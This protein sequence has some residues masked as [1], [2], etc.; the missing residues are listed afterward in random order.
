MTIFTEKEILG[1]DLNEILSLTSDD[2]CISLFS[3][4]FFK[5]APT[6]KPRFEVNDY[7]KLPT[8]KFNTKK[9]VWT[10]IGIYLVNLHLIRPRFAEIFGYINKPF[11]GKVLGF[12]EGKLSD[13]LYND[14]ISTDDMA[15][16]Y[17][18]LQW[19]GGHDRFSL[20]TPS[21]T[22]AL[23][24]PAPGLM[25][26]KRELFKKYEKELDPSN[27]NNAL[28]AA[29]I[30][31]ELIE[32]AENYLKTCEGYENFSSKS[33]VN[34]G[35][36]YK[37]MN[38]MKG[39]LLN[40]YT[41]QYQVNESEYNTGIKKGEYVSMSDSAVLGAH[42]RAVNTA[43]GGYLAKK[44]NQA[45][46]AVQAGPKGSDCKTKKTYQVYIYPEMKNDYLNRYIVE[47]GKLIELTIDNIDKYVNTTVN[48]RSPIYCVMEEPCY[49][50]ICIGNQPY[51]LGLDKFGLAI[52]RISNKLL[53]LSMK[54]FHDL[55][56]KTEKIDTKKLFDFKE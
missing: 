41:G 39:P 54:K 22:S 15:D 3:K 17:N 43:K 9:E 19:I 50:N 40:S 29:K 36:N 47:D 26:K 12:I 52:N 45:L 34:I 2:I 46:N 48:M 4:Y 32:Y 16:Y 24:K 14:K 42:A 28:V 53:T 31:K 30:E 7:F 6:V 56:V 35:N 38:I 5:T 33:K 1:E 10:T 44:S 8:S 51:M 25:E 11:D 27:P 21:V 20:L 37:T 23:L 49:C 18:R 13:A 55:T